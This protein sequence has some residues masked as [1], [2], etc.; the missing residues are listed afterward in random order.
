ME[1]PQCIKHWGY[2]SEEDRQ[3][4]MSQSTYIL[5]WAGASVVYTT[6]YS[7]EMTNGFQFRYQLWLMDIDSMDW[8]EVILF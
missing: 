2:S 6:P 4:H 3:N 5:V 1:H 7:V 8:C